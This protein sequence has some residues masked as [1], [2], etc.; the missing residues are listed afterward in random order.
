MGK[1]DDIF[2]EGNFSDVYRWWRAGR[3]R[4]RKYH[5]AEDET[6]R[7]HSGASRRGRGVLIL[8]HGNPTQ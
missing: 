6:V 4:K 3:Q 5:T 7:Q 8:K 2:I 1:Q